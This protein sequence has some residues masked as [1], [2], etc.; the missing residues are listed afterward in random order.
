MTQ[1][2]PLVV[3][4]Y[5][6]TPDALEKALATLQ[7]IKPPTA[8]LWCVFGCGGNRDRG[9]RLLM[10]AVAAAGSDKVVVTSDNPRL[11]APQDIIA[12]ILPAVPH[13]EYVEADR[14][15]AITYAIQNAASN[16]VILIAGKGHETYQ[17]IQGQ[18]HYFSDFDIARAA[19]A[20]RPHS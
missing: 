11:E 14:C 17:D 2:Q 1:G 18:K 9:K 10:G 13:P 3:V 15:A 16:D 19:L 8:A 12:D 20:Q 5:A 7:E 6:H 4:D